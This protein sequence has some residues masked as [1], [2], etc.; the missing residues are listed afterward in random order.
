VIIRI[1]TYTG[2]NLSV[3]YVTRIAMW[4]YYEPESSV[5]PPEL[6]RR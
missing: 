3:A 1:V 4:P 2:V 6:N 5:L